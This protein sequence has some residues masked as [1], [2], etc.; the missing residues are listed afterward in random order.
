[1]A[2]VKG[3]SFEVP[4]AGAVSFIGES[5][6]GR[7]T[8]GRI[9][10]GLET[11]DSGVILYNRENLALL[12][13]HERQKRLKKVQ[14]IQQD[15]YAALNPSRTVSQSLVAPLTYEAKRQRQSQDWIGRRVH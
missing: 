4:D 8:V 12:P 15:P 6:C 9:L 3:I 13:A 5:G 11:Y 1:M 14:L 10:T 7:T 2:A